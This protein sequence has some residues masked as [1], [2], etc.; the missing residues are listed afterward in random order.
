MTYFKSE[1]HEYYGTN[2]GVLQA[3]DVLFVGLK[4]SLKNLRSNSASREL[5]KKLFKAF[6]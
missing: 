4:L 3:I 1:A 6:S 5:L 2:S